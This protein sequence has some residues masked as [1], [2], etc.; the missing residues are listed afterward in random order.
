MDKYVF[1]TIDKVTQSIRPSESVCSSRIRHS[2]RELKLEQRLRE[3]H[4]EQPRLLHLVQLLLPR[5][6]LADQVGERSARRD[7]LLRVLDL[8]L[9]LL[10]QFNLSDWFAVV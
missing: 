6:R 1:F 7:K 8:R 10:V 5:L 9:L 3:R 4:L 2:L